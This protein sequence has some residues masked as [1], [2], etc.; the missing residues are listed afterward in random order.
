MQVGGTVAAAAG[1]FVNAYQAWRTRKTVTLQ[2]LQD[3]LK[4]MNERE[5]A[6]AASKD[7]GPKQ[8]HA[9][10]EFLNFLEIYSAA[11]NAQ[12]FVGVAREIVQDKILDSIVVLEHSPHWHEEIEKSITSET[13]YKHLRRFVKTNRSTIAARKHASAQALVGSPSSA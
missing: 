1:L 2:H 9:F 8:L 7:D 13:T 4:A 6:L 5:A 11:I 12:L 3:F 10:I